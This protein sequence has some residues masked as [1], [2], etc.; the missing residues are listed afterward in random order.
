MSEWV[1]AVLF[2]YR[3]AVRIFANLIGHEIAKLRFNKRRWNAGLWCRN[4][5]KGADFGDFEPRSLVIGLVLL[6]NF[7]TSARIFAN[8]IELLICTIYWHTPRHEWRGFWVQ[9]ATKGSAR[10]ATASVDWGLPSPNPSVDAPT[11]LMFKLAFLSRSWCRPHDEQV[12]SRSACSQAPAWEYGL[13]RSAS[14]S[15]Y[16]W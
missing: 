3:L 11:L 16:K 1:W 7:C 15:P 13:G 4:L 12:H 2:E 14:F 6:T 8:R 10:G 5:N 9:A